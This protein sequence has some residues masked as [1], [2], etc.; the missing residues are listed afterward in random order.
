MGRFCRLDLL[1]VLVVDDHPGGEVEKDS[2]ELHQSRHPLHELLQLN[3]HARVSRSHTVRWNSSVIIRLI[4][5]IQISIAVLHFSYL[6]LSKHNFTD[7]FI[8]MFI[9]YGY[10]FV[11][12]N[13]IFYTLILILNVIV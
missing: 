6:F 2:A 10:Y 13:I 12:K 4:L 3:D 7:L 11:S 8:S 9:F 5:L 1:P